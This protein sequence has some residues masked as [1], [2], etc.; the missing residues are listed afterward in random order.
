[1]LFFSWKGIKIEMI[2]N[3]YSFTPIESRGQRITLNSNNIQID[4]MGFQ[5]FNDFTGTAFL[6]GVCQAFTRNKFNGNS[7]KN[8]KGVEL[9]I[10]KVQ[11]KDVHYL[12]FEVIADNNEIWTEFFDYQ[13]VCMIDLALGKAVNVFSL[14]YAP[15]Q[16]QCRYKNEP[17]Q[18]I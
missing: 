12:R 6:K 4:I 2:E 15:N 9:A 18:V 16:E 1:M 5:L 13:E 11:K 7:Y 14:A 10:K 8:E 17:L 3:R